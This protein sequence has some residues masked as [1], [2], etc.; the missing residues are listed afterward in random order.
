MEGKLTTVLKINNIYFEIGDT[1]CFTLADGTE[2]DGTIK[3][4]SD[5]SIRVEIDGTEKN[6]AL[7]DV[8][9]IWK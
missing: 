5:Y 4:F 1:I 9:N 2:W 3:T 8:T 7:T 6:I